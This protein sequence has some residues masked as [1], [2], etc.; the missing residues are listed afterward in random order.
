VSGYSKPRNA[1]ARNVDDEVY[2]AWYRRAI[3]LGGDVLEFANGREQGLLN[4]G[5]CHS[6][7]EPRISTRPSI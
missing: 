5:S 7:S 3:A 1:L 4:L 6:R 2:L